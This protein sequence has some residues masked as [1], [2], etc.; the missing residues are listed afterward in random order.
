MYMR[1]KLFWIFMWMLLC[2]SV[3]YYSTIAKASMHERPYTA[4]CP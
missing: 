3:G 2:A 4:G 1:E